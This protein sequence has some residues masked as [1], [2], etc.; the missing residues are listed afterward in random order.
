MRNLFIVLGL[1][2]LFFLYSF[3][4][5]NLENK[6]T[7]IDITFFDC[8]NNHVRQNIL[9]KIDEQLEII[10]AVSTQEDS[11][12]KALTILKEVRKRM[13]G[14]SKINSIY[15]FANCISPK[16]N[17]FKTLVQSR[18]NDGKMEQL[19]GDRHTILKHGVKSWGYNV[20]SKKYH[21]SISPDIKFFAKSHELHWLSFWPETRYSNVTF[22]GIIDFEGKK[23]FKLIFKDYKNRPVNFYYDFTTYLPLAFNLKTNDKGGFVTTYFMSW[24]QQNGVKI[25]KKAKLLEGDKVFHYDFKDLKINTL[26]DFD[27]ESKN[28]SIK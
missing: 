12:I 5:N 6:S 18:K 11:K 26:T 24:E 15:A 8:F 10:G 4:T 22:G 21:D 20:K 28:N 3:K 9:S 13:G 1:C 25:F 27:F 23:A 16:G 17:K 19:S 7:A 14:V 2:V